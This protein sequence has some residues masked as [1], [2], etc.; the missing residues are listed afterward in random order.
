M[1]PSLGDEVVALPDSVAPFAAQGG[2]WVG[3]HAGLPQ[4]TAWPWETMRDDIA[5]NIL[6]LLEDNLVLGPDGGV[7][8]R[9]ARYRVARIVSRNRSVLHPPLDRE[10]TIDVLEDIL[11]QV[12]GDVRSARVAINGKAIAGPQL[13]DLH[14]WLESQTFTHFE[15]PVPPPTGIRVGLWLWLGVG[16]LLERATRPLHERGVRERL[17]GV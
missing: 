10:A 3:L 1:R 9:E 8:Q 6:R 2:D 12:G 7:W 11:T 16:Y 13:A 5:N 17:S 14:T 4:S 15:R